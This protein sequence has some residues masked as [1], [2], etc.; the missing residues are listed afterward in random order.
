MRDQYRRWRVM[1]LRRLSLR[2]LGYI[3]R[4]WPEVTE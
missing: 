2:S 4:F 1:M 3:I